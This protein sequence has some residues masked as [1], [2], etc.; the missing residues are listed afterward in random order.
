MLNR[1]SWMLKKERISR[2]ALPLAWP[3]YAVFTEIYFDNWDSWYRISFTSN[4]NYAKRFDFELFFSPLV[5]CFICW[6][7]RKKA[8]GLSEF[9]L[10]QAQI[11]DFSLRWFCFRLGLYFWLLQFWKIWSSTS[12]GNQRS[13]SMMVLLRCLTESSSNALSKSFFKSAFS[14]ETKFCFSCIL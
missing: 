5:F 14:F 13:E 7:R 9:Y 6:F 10:V 2:Y 8:A 3:S 12:R 11:P 4:S 1:K